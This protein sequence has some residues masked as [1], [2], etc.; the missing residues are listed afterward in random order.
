MSATLS[1]K[2][3][4]LSA[5]EYAALVGDDATY[6]YSKMCRGESLPYAVRVAPRGDVTRAEVVVLDGDIDQMKADVK[7]S[8]R[9]TADF[10]AHIAAVERH[11]EDAQTA[12]YDEGRERWDAY[13]AREEKQRDA[14]LAAP[15]IRPV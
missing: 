15:S 13:Q 14:R 4:V 3:V 2:L 11:R 9:E 6:V 10:Y 12:W 1:G 8:R 7:Q 5:A